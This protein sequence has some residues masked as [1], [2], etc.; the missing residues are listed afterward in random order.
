MEN[1]TPIAI[2]CGCPVGI[3]TEIVL[4][5]LIQLNPRPGSYLLIG[6]NRLWEA[7]AN[8][9]TRNGTPAEDLHEL[10]SSQYVLWRDPSEE[11][12]A[13]GAVD[14]RSLRARQGLE[15]RG[16]FEHLNVSEQEHC[17]ETQKQALILACDEA[18][19]GRISGIVTAPIRK[20]AL[21]NID[22]ENYPG[23]TELFDALL[24]S[25]NRPAQMCFTGAGFI[26]TLASVH[27]PLT[28]VPGSLTR[29]RVG[30]TLLNSIEAAATFRARS[31][32]CE[33]HLEMQTSEKIRV[34]VLGLNPHAGE[35]GLMGFEEAEVITPVIETLNEELAESLDVDIRG[36]F[37]ADTYFARVAKSSKAQEGDRPDV[38]VAMYHD[39]GLSAYKVL[40]AGQ[41]VNWTHG[42][43]IPRTSPDH[44]TADSIAWRGIADEASMVAALKLAQELAG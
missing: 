11:G 38:V 12:K 3:G 41:G 2:T 8:L 24:N 32:G 33:T 29:E 14:F 13:E 22:G 39:Q 36:P 10:F 35:N 20:R 6:P 31:T 43:S 30:Q 15:A 1:G 17:L 34:D 37:P 7:A 44:G 18:L 42:L 25:S 27:M 9:L 28:E 19:Q 26:L 16:L 5:A 21:Q 23:H 4:K 40:S